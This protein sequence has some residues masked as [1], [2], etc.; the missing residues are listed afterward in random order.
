MLSNKEFEKLFL[1]KWYFTKKKNDEIHNTTI[2]NDHVLQDRRGVQ[3][4]NHKQRHKDSMKMDKSNT[5]SLSSYVNSILQVHEIL[6]Q[7][8]VIVSIH[9]S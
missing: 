2:N 1:H 8:K 6:Q 9:P 7:K 5:T 3:M 4:E